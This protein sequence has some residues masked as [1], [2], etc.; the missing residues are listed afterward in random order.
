MRGILVQSMVS[1]GVPFDVALRT[2]TLV[3]DELAERGEVAETEISKLVA[4]LL[5][6]DYALDAAAP[7]ALEEPPAVRSGDASTP[8]SKGILSVSLEGSGLDRGEAF[9]VAMRVEARL[10][11]EGRKEIEREELRR[12]VAETLEEVHGRSAATRYR[13]WRAA[14]ADPRPIFLLVGGSTGAGKTSIGV[15]VARRLEIPHVIGTDSIRQI[16]RLMFSQDLMPEIYGSTFDAYRALPAAEPPP[17]AIAGMRGQAQ[18]IAVGVHA[19]LDR[20][21]E[22]NTSLVVEGANLVP[23]AL[24]LDRYRGSAHVIFLV[25]GV[26]SGEDFRRRFETRA[27]KARDRAAGRYLEHLSEILEIQD[28]IM[29]EADQHGLPIIDNVR[30]DEAVL[31]VIRSVISTLKKSVALPVEEPAGEAA[32]SAK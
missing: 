10:Q 3:R 4:D 19:L 2:A 12:S 13:V 17:D 32:G 16:M 31:S 11:G 24:D 6:A 8:F 18:K 20:A 9:E 23:G 7:R 5:P 27:A 29:A 30:F 28:A 26:L 1:R 21:L 22:E 25:V 15:E 14:D